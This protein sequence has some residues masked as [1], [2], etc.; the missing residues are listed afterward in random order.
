MDY[1]DIMGCSPMADQKKLKVAYLKAAKKYHPDVYDGPNKNHFQR[2]S[3][4][5][6]VLKHERKRKEYDR[7]QKI[8]KMRD[9]SAFKAET[10]KREANGEEFT[11]EM[12]M[13]MRRAKQKER[14]VREHQDPEFEEALRKVDLNRFMYDFEKRPMRSDPDE[15]AENLCVPDMDRKMSKRDKFRR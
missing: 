10:Q 11:Y 9:S 1:Y 14:V 5:Y 15:L 3:E 7:K 13:A 2:V 4:A 8:Y 12:F 6:N